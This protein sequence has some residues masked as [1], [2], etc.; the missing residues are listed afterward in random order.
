[1]MDITARNKP[2]EACDFDFFKIL[3]RTF[4]SSKIARRSIMISEWLVPMN[5]PSSIEVR[6]KG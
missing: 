2:V 5:M 4:S 3:R 6:L 1:M